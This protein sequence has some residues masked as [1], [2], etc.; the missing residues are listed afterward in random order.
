VKRTS[1]TPHTNTLRAVTPDHPG[2]SDPDPDEAL[3]RVRA[4]QIRVETEIAWYLR[5]RQ[6]G[7]AARR[8]LAA[9]DAA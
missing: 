9:R 2:D 6:T 5:D 8:E 7:D 3:R 4:A 1:A